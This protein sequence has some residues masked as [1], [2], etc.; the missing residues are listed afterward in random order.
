LTNGVG[1]ALLIDHQG[2]TG[3]VLTARSA[4]VNVARI[5]KTGKGFFNGGTQSS[6]ADVAEAFDVEGAFES[7]EPGDVLVISADRDRTV[8]KSGE[9]YST[10][11]AGVYATKPGLLLTEK[12]LD[13]PLGSMVPMGIVGVL[14]TKVSSENGP[15]RRGD[16]LVTASLPGCA[17]KGTNRDRML[18]A[19]LGKALENFD[20]TTTGV[21]NV[22][23]NTR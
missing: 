1:T 22:L 5:D 20:G 10:L 3:N 8:R 18:G 16:L 15:I 9:P 4:G 2:S 13:D 17:M 23:V 12:G 19:V 6:G 14:P 21:I 7:Y 11:I